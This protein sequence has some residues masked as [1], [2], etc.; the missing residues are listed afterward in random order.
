M[1]HSNHHYGES[2]QWFKWFERGQDKAQ[3]FLPNA[4][5]SFWVTALQPENDYPHISQGVNRCHGFLLSHLGLLRI[6]SHFS[7]PLRYTSFITVY[8]QTFLKQCFQIWECHPRFIFNLSLTVL[9]F[10]LGN[11]FSYWGTS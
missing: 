4:G 3:G 11:I 7:R 10:L 9:L 8:L 6:S 1:V 2:K 5:N